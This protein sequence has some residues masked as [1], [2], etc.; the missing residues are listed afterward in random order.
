M[1]YANLIGKL[2]GGSGSGNF[3]HSGRPG[4]RGGSAAGKGSSAAGAASKVADFQ[5]KGWKNANFT[6]NTV[7]ASYRT[8][9]GYVGVTAS[10][11]EGGALSN[12]RVGR[13][14]PNTK[15]GEVENPVSVGSIPWPEEAAW[16]SGVTPKR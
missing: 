6:G 11:N 7:Y 14:T 8:D 1:S 13:V 9:L 10:V 12:I 16:R 15:S 2:K 3:G 4:K 5:A